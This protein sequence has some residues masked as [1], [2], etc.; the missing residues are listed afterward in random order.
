VIAAVEPETALGGE[1]SPFTLVTH[2]LTVGN[3]FPRPVD[4]KKIRPRRF[5][6]G[7]EKFCLAKGFL[8]FPQNLFV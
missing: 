8:L 6:Y 1:H 7:S 5:V 2:N 3:I 4:R